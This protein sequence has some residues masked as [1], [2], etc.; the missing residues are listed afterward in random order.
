MKIT[1][2]YRAAVGF[3]YDANLKWHMPICAEICRAEQKYMPAHEHIQMIQ[4]CASDFFFGKRA[5]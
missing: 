1:C 3:S 2:P 4:R 5:R